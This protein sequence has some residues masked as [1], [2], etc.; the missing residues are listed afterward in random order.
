MTRART[1][2]FRRAAVKRPFTLNPDPPTFDD[3]A[4]GAEAT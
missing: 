2:Y 1:V 4:R 3:G